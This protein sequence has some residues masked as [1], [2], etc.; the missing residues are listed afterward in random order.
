MGK[1][2]ERPSLVPP[3]CSPHPPPIGVSGAHILAGA[4]NRAVPLLWLVDFKWEPFPKAGKKGSSGQ[5]GLEAESHLKCE[6]PDARQH[7]VSL[8]SFQ[9][10]KP[11][12]T[13]QRTPPARQK[14]SCPIQGSK[15]TTATCIAEI[16]APNGRYQRVACQ[17]VPRSKPSLLNSTKPGTH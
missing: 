16:A 7:Q 5:L 17:I 13:P 8:S 6:L 3:H 11:R 1:K 15:S 2:R 14:P 12:S 10:A 9:T 4:K